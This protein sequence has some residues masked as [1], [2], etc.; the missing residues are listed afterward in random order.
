[1]VNK[2]RISLLSRIIRPRDSLSLPPPSISCTVQLYIGER[3]SLQT[4]K[5]TRA[6][7]VQRVAEKGSLAWLHC[8]MFVV[9]GADYDVDPIRRAARFQIGELLEET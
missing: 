2:I 9:R 8:T 5:P 1:M 7:S 4:N 6:R 3:T